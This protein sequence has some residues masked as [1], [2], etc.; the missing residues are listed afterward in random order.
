MKTAILDLGTNTF[1]L[2]IAEVEPGGKPDV[3]VKETVPVKLGEGITEGIITDAAFR[4]GI[5]ALHNFSD[6]INEHH[7]TRIRAAGTAAFREAKNGRDFIKQV[8]KDT[9]ISIEMIDGDEEA[10]LIYEGVRHALKLPEAPVLI[11]DIGGGSVEFI[12]CN[13]TQIYWK[14]SY[15]IGAAKLMKLFHHT[16]P[17]SHEDTQ[18]INRFLDQQLTALR[19]TSEELKPGVLIGSAGAFE[20]FA[21]LESRKYYS[22]PLFP[23]KTAFQFD[24]DHF[25]HIADELLKTT[26]AQRETMPGLAEIRV[27]MIIVATILTR[28]ILKELNIKEMKMSVYSLKEGLLFRSLS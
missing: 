12:I 22:R 21:E 26:H 27:D 14:K 6:I 7:V 18:T 1:H 10:G 23:D 5:D 4:R 19:I 3:L 17:I 2:L 20:T 28:Y 16:D 9:G 25:N 24:M 11:M 15:P 8:K 13:Q